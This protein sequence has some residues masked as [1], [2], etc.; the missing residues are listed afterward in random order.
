MLEKQEKV[1]KNLYKDKE[2]KILQLEN[3]ILKNKQKLILLTLKEELN[4]QKNSLQK[5]CEFIDNE[6]NEI[7]DRELKDK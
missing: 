6:L 3:S 2:N 1:N 7:I 4:K 5:I